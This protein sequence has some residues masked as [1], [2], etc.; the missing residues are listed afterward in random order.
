MQDCFCELENT[1]CVVE[2]LAYKVKC[3]CCT[4]CNYTSRIPLSFSVLSAGQDRRVEQ[5][6]QEAFLIVSV[7]ARLPS[8]IEERLCSVSLMIVRSLSLSWF[9]SIGNSGC[10]PESRGST[11]HLRPS[12]DHVQCHANHGQP[13]IVRSSRLQVPLRMG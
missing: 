8:R 10:L 9:W 7:N 1:C 11:F 12:L 6:L 2:N 5:N 4:E 13:T 3:F